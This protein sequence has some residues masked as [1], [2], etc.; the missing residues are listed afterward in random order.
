MSSTPLITVREAAQR[1]RVPPAEIVRL[2]REG[3]IRS[4]I[5]GFQR[6][7]YLEDV[8]HLEA[9]ASRNPAPSKK[10][11]QS[12]A[13]QRPPRRPRPPQPGWLTT[14]EAAEKLGISPDT[15]R[16]HIR[17]GK[18]KSQKFCGL[19][20][21][22]LESLQQF[23]AARTALQAER[24]RAEREGFVCLYRAAHMLGCSH[25]H[26]WD[27]IMRYRLP[28][29][30]VGGYRYLSPKVIEKVRRLLQ[31]RQRRQAEGNRTGV[32]QVVEHRSPKPKVGG[33]SPSTR[34]TE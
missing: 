7:L 6:L 32:A 26:L 10:E 24:E 30:Y 33:S 16:K 28:S 13:P 29:R 8:Q 34:A 18:L 27:I 11:M 5:E 2:A 20:Y 4:R 31:Q 17:T 25:G 21:I 23:I 19:R 1:L 9:T 22:D 3:R 14:G 12:T 15:V